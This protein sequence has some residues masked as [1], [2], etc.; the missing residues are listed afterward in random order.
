VKITYL[1]LSPEGD[2]ALKPSDLEVPFRIRP[3][4]THPSMTLGGYLGALADLV[5][6]D[7]CR[8]LCEALREKHLPAPEPQDI[9]EIII[10]TEK[11][12]AFY[13]IASVEIPAGAG[14]LKLAAST[15]V[16]KEARD[17]LSREAGLMGEL[18]RTLRVPVLPRPILC[19]EVLF[20]GGGKADA[21]LV[22]LTDWFEDFHE[23]HL[24]GNAGGDADRIRLWDQTRGYRDA[25]AGEACEIFREIARILTLLYDPEGF[26]Q[27]LQWHHAAGDFIVKTTDGALQVRLTTVRHFGPLPG[28]APEDGVHPMVALVYFFLNMALCLRLD[29]EEGVGRPLWAGDFSLR[30]AV[31]GFFKGLEEAAALGRALP[32][33]VEETRR[34]L[35]SFTLEELQKMHQP[36]LARLEE[37]DAGERHLVRLRLARHLEGLYRL[38]QGDRG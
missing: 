23:W 34:L 5:L 20:P 21:L 29:R 18:D 33:G 30:C 24:A 19:Q 16:T 6:R 1:A 11:H 14:V 9:H 28:L 13:H 17:M 22:L 36:V 35:E 3:D 15:A 7:G 12:G 10:R 4:A 2:I 32:M 25:S 27:I 38:I 37:E 31:E 26:G 8:P